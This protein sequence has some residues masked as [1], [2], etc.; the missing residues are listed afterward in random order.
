VAKLSSLFWTTVLTT[1]MP[2]K[3]IIKNIDKLTVILIYFVIGFSFGYSAQL[4]VHQEPENIQKLLIFH[5]LNFRGRKFIYGIYVLYKL[6]FILSTNLITMPI[7]TETHSNLCQNQNKIDNV[8]GADP[9]LPLPIAS[10]THQLTL[11]W[12]K[13]LYHQLRRVVWKFP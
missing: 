12:T 10:A 8:P 1:A 5:T 11:I 4:P 13:K 2:N 3:A 6:Y 7:L 9:S